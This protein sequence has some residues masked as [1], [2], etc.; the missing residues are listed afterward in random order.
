MIK[1]HFFKKEPLQNLKLQSEMLQKHNED[2]SAPNYDFLPS[3]VSELQ[4]KVSKG[5]I[6]Q[7]EADLQIQIA[8][9]NE[10][11]NMGYA[12]IT[13]S[14]SDEARVFLIKN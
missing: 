6:T 9:E 2:F 7:K 10:L 3:E 11:V 1:D 5:L 4:Q 8:R 14:H 12:F 13:F